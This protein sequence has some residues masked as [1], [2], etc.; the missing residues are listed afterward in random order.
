[1]QPVFRTEMFCHNKHQCNSLKLYA[2]LFQF[3]LLWMRSAL[4]NFEVG[5]ML[6][7][8]YNTCQILHKADFG[9]IDAQ[10]TYCF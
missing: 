3:P 9:G 1:L 10:Q 8:F 4:C 7:L 5:F 6:K 2:G